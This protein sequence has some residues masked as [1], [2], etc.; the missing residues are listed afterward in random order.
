[1]MKMKYKKINYKNFP[2]TQ[3]P[4][5]AEN[6]NN[7]DN[8]IEYLCQEEEKSSETVA[9]LK[10]FKNTAEDDISELKNYI[11]ASTKISGTGTKTGYILDYGLKQM[12]FNIT[13]TSGATIRTFDIPF[14]EG[15]PDGSFVENHFF[16]IEGCV[17]YH[18]SGLV[19]YPIGYN[20]GRISVQA[21]QMEVHPAGQVVRVTYNGAPE[22]VNVR[23][24]GIIKYTTE[25]A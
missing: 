25:T 5:N 4:L 8:A 7:M 3:T 16:G 6:L 12:A 9:E 20:D 14:P 10:T 23:L 11:P 24:F 17:G 1:M 15:V 22:S 19:K 21:K 2:S 18:N 13:D